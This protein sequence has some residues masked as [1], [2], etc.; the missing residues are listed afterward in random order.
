[1][2]MLGLLVSAGLGAAG[3]LLAGRRMAGGGMTDGAA[4]PEG[5]QRLVHIAHIRSG[6]EGDLRRLVEDRFPVSA[7]AGT[8][9]QEVTVFIGSTYLLSEYAFS[10]EYTP[11]FAGFR[12][13]P[14]IN[15]YLEE[16]GRL[17]DDEPAPLPDAPAMQFIASQALHWDS[18]S[19][20]VTYTP[21]MRPKEAST[22]RV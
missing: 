21:R 1:M 8:G 15:A 11:T 12:N 2:R 9:I 20:R 14:T 7:L 16:I 6:S 13:N 18:R 19:G 10:G 17:L 4:P 22:D 3:G 5:V